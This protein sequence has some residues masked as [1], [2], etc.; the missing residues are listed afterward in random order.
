M[1]SFRWPV[2]VTKT[3]VG[4]VGVFEFNIKITSLT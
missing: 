3:L 2:D 1:S 4:D